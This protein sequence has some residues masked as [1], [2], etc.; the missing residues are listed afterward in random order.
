MS[1]KYDSYFDVIFEWYWIAKRD[2][3]PLVNDLH[4]GII[5]SLH[6][7]LSIIDRK[8]HSFPKG[9]SNGVFPWNPDFKTG[10]GRVRLRL[11]CQ[12]FHWYS[13]FLFRDYKMSQNWP[14]SKKVKNWVKKCQEIPIIPIYKNDRENTKIQ[15]FY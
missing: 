1:H 13:G 5:T 15:T 6:L 8:N 2:V 7:H 11:K 14:G 10:Y 9:L 4:V 3:L 12:N